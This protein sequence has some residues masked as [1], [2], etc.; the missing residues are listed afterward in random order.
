MN[1]LYLLLGW[2]LG[3]LS[4]QVAERI[5][6]HY[7]KS[8]LRCGIISELKEIKVRVVSAVYLLAKKIGTYD[9]ELIEWVKKHLEGYEGSYPTKRM[10]SSL[11]KL[12]NQAN[13]QQLETIQLLYYDEESGL[14]LKKFYLPFLES[15]IDSLPV[16]SDRFRSLIFE[17]RSQ[18][19]MLN[20]EIDNAQF[21]FR[22]TFDS[23][24][25]AESHKIVRQNLKSCY[26]NIERQ[27]RPMVEKINDLIS[28]KS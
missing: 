16:F 4:P 1:V 14:S 20:E 28:C 3:L 19:Q 15:R 12:S 13:N 2:L 5:K 21:Y 23:S 26:G 22:K 18:I 24:M 27:I 10:L 25:N 11:E 17:I 6:R 9:K 8:D 7:Q